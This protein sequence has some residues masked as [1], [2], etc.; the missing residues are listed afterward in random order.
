MMR[1][2]AFTALIVL[3]AAATPARADAP[4]SSMDGASINTYLAR[5]QADQSRDTPA[6]VAEVSALFL[7]MPYQVSPLGEGAGNPP[8]EDPRWSFSAADCQ[9]F[10][11]EAMALAVSRSFDA[12]KVHLDAIRYAAGKPS[13]DTRDHFPEAQWVPRNV[14]KGYVDE[15]TASI[16]GAAVKTY[17]KRIEPGRFSRVVD[18]HPLPLE[19]FPSGAFTFPYIPYDRAAALIDKVPGGAI[20]HIV[21][22]D[23]PRKAYMTS[24]QGVVVV[25]K[26]GKRERRYIRHASRHFGGKVG[27]MTL[28]SYLATLEKYETWPAL[29]IRV[30]LPSK[31]RAEP[32]SGHP[33]TPE[34]K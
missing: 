1:I 17:T 16:G 25:K 8:D 22:V 24:H 15:I 21:R 18:G 30:F 2:A 23:S 13:F 27:D 20:V 7:G 26:E 33:E 6:K 29:G 12:F 3:C 9:T 32:P 14:A 34:K 19:A 31:P 5:L 11:E 10:I 4:I 28:S